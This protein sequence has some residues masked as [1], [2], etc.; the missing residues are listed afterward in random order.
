MYKSFW[1]V[2]IF[3]V[4]LVLIS[5]VHADNIAS[6]EATMTAINARVDAGEITLTTALA[7]AINKD[8][9]FSLIVDFCRERGVALA[10]IV[11]VA[12]LTGMKEEVALAKLADA[13]VSQRELA[14]SGGAGT[15]G[16]GYT[17]A[18]PGAQIRTVQSVSANPGGSAQGGSVSPS[19]L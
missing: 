10:E 7:E 1:F 8:V 12:Q 9:S 19:S 16:L 3:L 5:P 6:D 11:S 13:G 14:A 15:T 18:A 17:P 2:A 4:S